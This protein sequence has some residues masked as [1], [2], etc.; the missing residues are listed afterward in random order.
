MVSFQDDFEESLPGIY[1]TYIYA[2]LLII[3]V[4]ILA[5]YSLL[6]VQTHSVTISTPSLSTFETLHNAYSETL[7]CPCS[8]LAIP[9]TKIY[10]F[11]DPVYHPVRTSY[12]NS[13]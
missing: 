3:S 9:H 13:K 4:A 6:I 2:I 1:T 10:N 12:L 5:F 8:Q 7:D 11:S